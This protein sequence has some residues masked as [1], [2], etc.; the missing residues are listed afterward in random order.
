MIVAQFQI[1]K[2]LRSMN[3]KNS[4]DGFIFNND[5]IINKHIDPVTGVNLLAF[6]I[7]G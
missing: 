5:D 1:G 6:I 7:D 2:D 4:I 3:G